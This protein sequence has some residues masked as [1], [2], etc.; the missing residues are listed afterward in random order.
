VSTGAYRIGELKAENLLL[1]EYVARLEA[2][3]QYYVN[4]LTDMGFD[5]GNTARDALGLPL[6]KHGATPSALR[7][8][9]EGEA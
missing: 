5:D 1:R 9:D 6:E 7:A 2:A 3:L 4:A 8:L